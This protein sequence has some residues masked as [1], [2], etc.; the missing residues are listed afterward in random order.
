MSV[1]VAGRNP[2]SYI[3]GEW[4]ACGKERRFFKNIVI[5]LSN[6]LHFPKSMIKSKK[7]NDMGV[8]TALTLGSQMC[9][10]PL[11]TIA[12]NLDRTYCQK[13]AI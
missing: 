5:F 11:N 7:P 10:Y 8:E 2:P 6:Y 12:G 4:Q 3:S 13:P 9:E 1:S